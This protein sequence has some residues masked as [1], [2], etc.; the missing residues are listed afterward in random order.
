M[1]YYVLVENIIEPEP[2]S[3][4]LNLDTDIRN[5]KDWAAFGIGSYLLVLFL[6]LVLFA[7]AKDQ[8]QWISLMSMEEKDDMTMGM[9]TLEDEA[10]EAVNK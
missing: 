1:S 10:A 2:P 5:F 3:A 9:Q 7:R 6:T 8:E 4:P